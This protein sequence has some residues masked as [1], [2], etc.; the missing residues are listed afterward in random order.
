M[1]HPKYNWSQ[2]NILVY[3]LFHQAAKQNEM[4]MSQ[5]YLLL[6]QNEID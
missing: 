2:L 1:C 6:I 5:Q 4:R 3:R